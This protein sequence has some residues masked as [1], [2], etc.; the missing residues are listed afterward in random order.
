MPTN[1]TDERAPRVDRICIGIEVEGV[2]RI[3]T[4]WNRPAVIGQNNFHDVF[5]RMKL[6]R[7]RSF[8][9]HRGVYL[10]PED[11]EHG[12]GADGPAELVSSPHYFTALNLLRLRNSIWKSLG[13]KGVVTGRA[14]FRDPRLPAPPAPTTAESRWG[15][16]RLRQIGGSLQTT[17]GLSV[18]RLLGNTASRHALARLLVGNQ[19][20]RAKLIDIQ[21]A[22]VAAEQFLTAPGR[23]LFHVGGQTNPIRLVLFMGLIYI[24]INKT[25]ALGDAVWGKD[26]LGCNFK[27]YTSFVG[28]GVANN[29]G[30]L[31][32][33]MR[34]T[35]TTTT[36]FINGIAAI[37]RQ[38]WLTRALSNAAGAGE[39]DLSELGQPGLS[40]QTSLEEWF[41]IPNFTG[42]NSLCTVVECREKTANLNRHV[43]DFFNA[44][45]QVVAENHRS[46]L[47]QARRLYDAVR[48]L[49]M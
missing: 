19:E 46:S 13:T 39:F 22:A 37:T 12:F 45:K 6:V 17:I 48:I 34:G 38:T 33:G 14:T 26:A 20:K 7:S 31:K 10:T 44:H 47:R 3:R 27:G 42:H 40:I 1:I 29:N 16:Y 24:L 25:D 49:I 2:G 36:D 11:A 30:I 4:K 18:N 23:P 9:A 21:N 43:R 35:G 8:N 32:L 5:K 15:R 41:A 28:C